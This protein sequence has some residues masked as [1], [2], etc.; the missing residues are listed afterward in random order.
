[1]SC[2]VV[3]S[4]AADLWQIPLEHL[5]QRI[6]DGLV[7]VLREQGWT[8]VDVAPTS[9]QIQRPNLPP[10]QRPA[11]YSVV[12]QE[13]E[14][15]PI[16]EAEIIAL[17]DATADEDDDAGAGETGNRRPDGDL[18]G[19]K[20]LDQ[21]DLSEDEETLIEDESVDDVGSTNYTGWQAARQMASR[22]RKPP[23][24]QRR[25]E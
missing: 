19:E 3:P 14:I 24:R 10:A 13:P 22:L 12:A 6:R 21:R 11:T 20:P 18:L 4:L 7:P 15:D 9:H 2:W 25:D 8:F 23:P 1:M 17:S 16:T 5:M